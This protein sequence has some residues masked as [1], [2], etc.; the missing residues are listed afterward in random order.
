V[1]NHRLNKTTLTLLNLILNVVTTGSKPSKNVLSHIR[2]EHMQCFSAPFLLLLIPNLGMTAKLAMI[3]FDSK[4]CAGAN[5]SNCNPGSFEANATHRSSV[6]PYCDS[7]TMQ[8]SVVSI[9]EKSGFAHK[10]QHRPRQIRHRNWQRDREVAILKGGRA[11]VRTGG[12]YRR[13]EEGT[14][15]ALNPPPTK[16]DAHEETTN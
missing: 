13:T 7:N 10:P 8:T 6:L 11:R 15:A 14:L 9:I 12:V 1:A 16:H 5:T 2:A 3:N 4:Q